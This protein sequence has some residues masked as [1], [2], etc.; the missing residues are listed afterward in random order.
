MAAHMCVNLLVFRAILLILPSAAYLNLSVF[1]SFTDNSS[2]CEIN[3]D[4]YVTL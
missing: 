2:V 4:R 1:G 3:F